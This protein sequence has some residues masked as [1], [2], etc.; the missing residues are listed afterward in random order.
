M[1]KIGIP[2][3]EVGRRM[4]AEDRTVWGHGVGAVLKADRSGDPE[5]QGEGKEQEKQGGRALG[6]VT[7]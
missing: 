7:W 3:V 4:K 1:S 6:T 2:Q 5:L